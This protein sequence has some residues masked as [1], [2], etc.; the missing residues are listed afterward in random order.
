M[1]LDNTFT[2]YLYAEDPRAFEQAYTFNIFPVTDDNPFFYNYFKWSNL[3]FNDA[4]QG[5]LNRFPIGNLILLTLFALSVATAILFIVAPL[6]RYQRNGLRTSGALP[7][8]AYFSLLGAGY[9]FVQIVLIQH[10]TL[11]I[12]Y[13]IHAVTT[14]IASM[15]A[16]SALGSLIG[17]RI[18]HGTRH[19]QAT[20]ALAASLIVVY[21]LALPPIFS[22][23]LRL[24]DVERILASVLLIAPLAT[25]MGMPFPTG[26]RQLGERA[27]QLAPWA[28]GMNGVFSVVGSVVVILVSMVS[29][30]TVALAC[31]ATCYLAAA[32]VCAAL[33]QSRLIHA[34]TP[35]QET[36]PRD[37]RIVTD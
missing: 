21:M 30:F 11:F 36:L 2:N 1:L 26:L 23:M 35:V 6:A 17:R 34:V 32:G 10:F 5:R 4:Y 29:N 22:A 28:W 16:F 27:P 20:L 13:P 12:G 37:S 8:L 15:L 25:V 24:S 18:L 14:T 19:L 33:W 31:G 3:H 9:I 7:V